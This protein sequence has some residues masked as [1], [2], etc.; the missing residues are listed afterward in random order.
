MIG[1]IRQKVTALCEESRAVRLPADC[2][3]D[4]KYPKL[5]PLMRF[6]VDRFNVPGFGHLM[7]MHTTT[8]MGMF[9]LSI[10]DAAWKNL[11]T[12]V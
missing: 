11:R 12:T 3:T 9:L 8:K 5:L 4:M 1:S 6:H 10:T 7:I 2:Y